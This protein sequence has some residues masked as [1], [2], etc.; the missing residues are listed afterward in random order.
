MGVEYKY[1]LSGHWFENFTQQLL[2]E[3]ANT[4]EAE[5]ELHVQS[6]RKFT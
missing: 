6:V 2:A 3:D 1:F 4:Y 5:N